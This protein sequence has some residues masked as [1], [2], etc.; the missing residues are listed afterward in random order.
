MDPTAITGVPDVTIDKR[1]T[2]P[3]TVGQT[4]LYTIVVRNLGTAATTGVVTVRD[5]LPSGLTSPVGAGAGWSLTDAP[6]EIATFAGAIAAGDSATF[7]VTV[8]VEAA[9]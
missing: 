1:D 9:A 4:G 8:D 5:T 3:F 6:I 7:T 2:T